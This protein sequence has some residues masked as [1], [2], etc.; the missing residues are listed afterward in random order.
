MKLAFGIFTTLVLLLVTTLVMAQ[1]VPP[2]V[3]ILV[4]A[5]ESH[6]W[7]VVAGAS[8]L[9]V[10]YLF[11]LPAL[12]ELW[13][14][15]PRRYRP[16]VVALLG[17]LS[18]VADALVSKR[19]WL[20]ALLSNLM[21][22]MVAIGTDQT[23]TKTLGTSPAAPVTY[24]VNIESDEALASIERLRIAAEE[25]NAAIRKTVPSSQIIPPAPKVPT[26]TERV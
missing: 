12:G 18:G 26:I 7:P 4:T 22:A 8:I 21:A 9:I 25:A 14:R 6:A 3:G 11:K 1:E 23:L 15:I 17:V 2:D 24:R 16:L 10:V 20:P 19:P 13:S 5:I